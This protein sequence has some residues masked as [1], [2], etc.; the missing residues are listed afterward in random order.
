MRR[1]D[2]PIEKQAESENEAHGELKGDNS[3]SDN[4]APNSLTLDNDTMVE[5]LKHLNYC[6]LAKSCLVSKRYRDV[7]QKNRHKL[8]L[9]KVN[10]IGIIYVPDNPSY[11]NM[12][13]KVL[14]REA[15]NDW[16]IRN[17][18]SEQ[19]PLESQFDEM[20][21]TQYERRVYQLWAYTKYTNPNNSGSKTVFYANAEFSHEN[22]SVFQH[23]V[24]LLTDPFIYIR[25]VE[26]VTQNDVLSLLAEAIKPD[27]L[28]CKLL[29]LYLRDDTQKFITRIKDHVFCNEFDIRVDIGSNYA[30]EFLN[31]FMTGRNCTSEICAE[32]FD[33]CDVI[34][35]FIQ[36][37]MQLKSC[38]EN[39][40]VESICGNVLNQSVEGMKRSFTE[41][42]AKE[43]EGYR[44]NMRIIEFVNNDIGKKLLLTI[45][46]LNIADDNSMSNFWIKIN[47]L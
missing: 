17:H 5:V 31:L 34:L 40:L 2:Q 46:N 32:N 39:Q 24:R 3:R 33:L 44:S 14:S 42:I 21:I 45:E 30:E 23:F 11:I 19:V 15:Y 7:I 9:L 41:L 12:F 36:K 4:S 38:D 10:D 35:G 26:L 43:E 22:W 1:S 20:Q 47:N 13:G 25:H 16:V 28:K 37:F 27:R 29:N 8:A 18:Y 6:Q